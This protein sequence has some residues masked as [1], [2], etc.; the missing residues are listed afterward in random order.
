MAAG[1]LSTSLTLFRTAAALLDGSAEPLHAAS[2]SAAITTTAMPAAA[3]AGR[4]VVDM[5]FLVIRTG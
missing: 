4:T 3:G 1:V 5:V 2:A